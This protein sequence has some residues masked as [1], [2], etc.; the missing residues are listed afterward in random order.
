MDIYDACKLDSKNK[1]RLKVDAVLATLSKK[2]S[3]SLIK[4]MLD[5]DI[6]THSI[7]R[8]L[9][10]NNIDCGCWAINQWRR[11]NGIKLRSTNGIDGK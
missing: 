2:D 6:S 3:E 10:G 5:P 4:A 1:R 7:E 8:V 11:A 9:K